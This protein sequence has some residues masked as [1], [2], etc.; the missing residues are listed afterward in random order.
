MVDSAATAMAR[1]IFAPPATVLVPVGRLNV[2]YWIAAL[3]LSATRLLG[4][5]LIPDVNAFPERPGVAYALIDGQRSKIVGY[6]E[7]DPQVIVNGARISARGAEVTVAPSTAFGQ[8]LVTFEHAEAGSVTTSYVYGGMSAGKFADTE[9]YAKVTADRDLADVFMILVVFEKFKEANPEETPRVAILGSSIGQLQAGRKKSIHGIFPPLKSDKP[10]Y[11]AALIFSEGLQI[12]SNEGNEALD[13]LFD[14]MD[15]AGLRKVIEERIVGDY[16]CKVY[17]S[18]PLKFGGE[19]RRKYV[20]Q[21]MKA[22]VEVSPS[23]FV[24]SVQ[25]DDSLD[26]VLEGAVANQLSYWL[27]LPRIIGGRAQSASVLLPIKF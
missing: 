19:L 5:N 2:R 14:I 18:S 4:D 24:E 21:T 9:F 10:L 15:H 25:I 27:F 8:G 13:G 6:R 11:W 3:V 7:R 17:R 23:G 12:R 16:P 26:P 20:G 22:R 1:Q